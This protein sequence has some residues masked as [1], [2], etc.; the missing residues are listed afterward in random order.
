MLHA[1]AHTAAGAAGRRF[2][3]VLVGASCPRPRLRDLLR[4]LRPGGRMAALCEGQLLLLALPAEGGPIPEP[5][6]LGA[7]PAADTLV[8]TP[9]GVRPPS[10][11]ACA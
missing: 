8:D 5:A 4:L 10:C 9:A 11:C 2:D 6:V 7:F 1:P 3:R